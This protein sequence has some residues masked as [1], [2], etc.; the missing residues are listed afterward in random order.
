MIPCDST[1]IIIPHRTDAVYCY[2]R[3]EVC[4]SVCL[5]VT[6]TSS[7]KTDEPI[8]MSFGD[9]ILGW[10]RGVMHQTE[11][12]SPQWKGAILGDI[13]GP[14]VNYREYPACGR[15]FQLRSTGG[16]SDAAFCCQYCSKFLL[17]TSDVAWTVLNTPVIYAKTAQPIETPSYAD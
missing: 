9:L 1:C 5:L 15:Y 2:R 17:Q 12:Q 4:T 11:A 13:S 3:S 16:S 8:K 7:A 10:A 14:I 6:T